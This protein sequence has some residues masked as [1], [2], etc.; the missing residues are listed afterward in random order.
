MITNGKKN[1]GCWIWMLLVTA[2]CIMA[3]LPAQA[4]DEIILTDRTIPSNTTW[5]VNWSVENYAIVTN[6]GTINNHSVF[7]NI[8]GAKLAGMGMFNNYSGAVLSN[9]GTLENIHFNN[10]SGAV[11]SNSGKLEDLSFN[12]NSGTFNNSG[13]FELYGLSNSGTLH[14][15]GKISSSIGVGGSLINSGTLNNSGGIDIFYGALGNSGTLTNAGG[16]YFYL[17]PLMNKGTFNNTNSGVITPVCSDIHNFS[18]AIFN[19]YGRIEIDFD[20]GFNNEGTFNNY[21]AINITSEFIYGFNNSGTLINAGT[22]KIIHPDAM[23][24]NS[25]LI[26][27]S[28]TYF[29][30]GGT[31]DNTGSISQESIEIQGGIFN[32][33]SGS[34]SATS[35]ANNGAFNFTGGTLSADSFTNTGLFQG[36]GTIAAETFTN[37]GTLAPGNSPGMLTMEGNYIQT[38]GG[39]LAIE[40]ASATSYDILNVTGEVS[41][42]GM[43]K[44]ILYD[45]YEPAYGTY[46]DFLTAELL[47]GK[48]DSI[49]GAAGYRWSV[50]YLDLIG[51]DGKIDTARLTANE[52]PIPA[53]LWLFV[54]G[55]LGIIGLRNRWKINQRSSI[56]KYRQAH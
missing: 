18:G 35:I 40:L 53:A 47:N 33:Q 41:L 56:L 15:S 2:L 51:L 8:S 10:Y 50:A 6:E 13:T 7:N 54:S 11:F 46:F 23:S 4:A 49:T 25:G 43:L 29:Q 52:V 44:V 9:S 31:S 36:A 34:L 16:I 20:A 19:N 24:K 21:G 27:G 45:H 37:A 3:W 12:T 30:T 1:S 22:L 38:T 55:M 26:T 48:F 14:N 42:A 32:Q 28:D 5:D 17:A 39:V